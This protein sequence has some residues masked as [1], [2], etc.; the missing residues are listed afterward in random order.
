[1][2]LRFIHGKKILKNS[3]SRKVNSTLSIIGTAG[4]PAKY[5]GFETVAE[6]IARYIDK[7]NLHI[8][9]TV[10]CSGKKTLDRIY[11]AK[12]TYIRLS[13]NGISSIFYD[14]ISMIISVKRSQDVILMLG[15]SGAIFIPLIKLISKVKFITNV[16]GIEWDRKKWGFLARNFLKISE[17]IAV[18]FSDKII[19]DNEG[20][21]NYLI[22]NYSL[23]SE[24]IAYGGDQSRSTSESKTSRF[25]PENYS[26]ALSRI[27]PENNVHLILRSFKSIKSKNLIYVGNWESSNYAR[28]L[29]A[30][31]SK[32]NNIFLFDPIYEEN[33]LKYIRNRCKIYIH[34]HSAGGTNPSLVEM[35]FFQKPIIAFNCSFNKYTT[36]NFADFF[37]TEQDLVKIIENFKIDEQKVRGLYNFAMS[38]YTWERIGKKYINLLEKL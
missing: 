19:S 35:M 36:N 21:Y 28:K 10:F 31:Y 38:N 3:S 13:A 32:Y 1:M 26:L 25:L 17:Y 22:E 4:I 14:L 2:I 6:N 37:D 11:G 27:E 23:E 8:S 29:K 7:N 5:G 9:A 34:G 15:V 30:E 12:L 24:M 18:K 16:D 33:Q 20:I